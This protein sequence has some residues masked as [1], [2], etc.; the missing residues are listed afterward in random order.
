MVYYNHSWSRHWLRKLCELTSISL[1]KAFCEF[2]NQCL[3]QMPF[4]FCSYCRSI[5]F[6]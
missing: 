4:M 2:F 5:I 6:K 1:I 3:L